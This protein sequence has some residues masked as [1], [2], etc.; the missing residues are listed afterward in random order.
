MSPVKCG[1]YAET[2]QAWKAQHKDITEASRAI[3][4][5]APCVFE[6]LPYYRSA[7]IRFAELSVRTV[8]RLENC[9]QNM[10]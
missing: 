3:G 2:H 7:I 5:S 1:V 10:A 6:E 8:N 4:C 9:A